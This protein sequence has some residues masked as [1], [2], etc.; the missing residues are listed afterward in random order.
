MLLFWL[1]FVSAHAADITS[2]CAAAFRL[3]LKGYVSNGK[4][5]AKVCSPAPA[6]C[7]RPAGVYHMY[8]KQCAGYV[9]GKNVFN[10]LW[11]TGNI[12]WIESTT[13]AHSKTAK[14]LASAR[15]ARWVTITVLRH[16]IDRIVAHYFATQMNADLDAWSTKALAKQRRGYDGSTRLWL[17]LEN[18]YTKL[19]SAHDDRRGPLPPDALE[20][21]DSRLKSDFDRVVIAEWLES[22]RTI[23]WLGDVMCFSHVAGVVSGKWPSFVRTRRRRGGKKIFEEFRKHSYESA[24]FWRAARPRLEDL[25]RRN[26]LDEELYTRASRRMDAQSADH[27]RRTQS[28]PLPAL[29]PLPCA[30][31]HCWDLARGGPPKDA[32]LAV[33]G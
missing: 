31:G 30:G 27:W 3:T 33:N 15:S 2:T 10:P 26:T 17:E 6:T 16:P 13:L 28:A 14:L 25:A 7:R 1:I 22:P 32:A 29:A 8:C 19:F 23:A 5:P 4:D 24:E 21:A 20:R 12:S 11:P 18:L 9:M